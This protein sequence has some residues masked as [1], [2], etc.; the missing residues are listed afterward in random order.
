VFPAWPSFTID[1]VEAVTRVLESGRVSYWTGD[2]GRRF[3]EEFAAH[4]GC[5]YAIAVAN[6]TVAL[7]LALY[8]LG[9]GRAMKL[10]PAHE[11]S[12]PQLL[13]L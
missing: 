7:E 1:E 4:A 3:E 5:K 9:I 8:A 10:L 13:A 12:S 6:G 11:P 2:E